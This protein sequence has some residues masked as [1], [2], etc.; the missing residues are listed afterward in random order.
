MDIIDSKVAE[1]WKRV[2]DKSP[3]LMKDWIQCFSSSSD[4]GKQ[5]SKEEIKMTLTRR[6]YQ[7]DPRKN[8]LWRLMSREPQKYGYVD[9]NGEC[10]RRADLA[11]LFIQVMMENSDWEDFTVTTLDARHSEINLTINLTNLNLTLCAQV[12]ENN[13]DETAVNLT[14]DSCPHVTGNNFDETMNLSVD[15]RPQTTENNLGET[16]TNFTLASRAQV[17]ENSLKDETTMNLTLASCPPVTE[18]NADKPITETITPLHKAARYENLKEVRK[19]IKDRENLKSNP[20]GYTPLHF[21]AMAI[22]PKHE[23]AKV[24]IGANKKMLNQQTA[25]EWG[26]NTALHIAAANTNVTE[27]FIQQFKD[28]KLQLPDSNN[29]TPFHV[30]AKS[31]NPQAII[32]MLN[33]FAPTNNCWDV[34]EVD[35]GQKHQNTLIKMCARRGNAK[36]VALLIKHGADISEGVLHEIVLQSVKTPK[37]I[38]KLVQ[39]YNSIVENVVTWRCL[40][41]QPEFLQT[42]ASDDYSKLFRETMIW[43]LTRPVK[44]YGGD[45]LQCALAHG[46][47]AMFWN[48]IN[49]KSVFRIQGD[50]IWKY[51]EEKCEH[52][53]SGCH[54]VISR[55]GGDET[56]RFVDREH[57]DGVDNNA[58]EDTRSSRKNWTVFDVTN[59]T[60]ETMLKRNPPDSAVES[61]DVT[62]TSERTALCSSRQQDE[63][64]QHA[65]ERS[66]EANNGQ[67]KPRQFGKPSVPDKPYLTCLLT[68]FDQWKCSNILSTQPFKELTESYI[69]FVQRFYFI[70]GLLQLIFMTSFTVFCMPTTCSLALMFSVSIKPAGCSNNTSNSSDNAM[71]PSFGQQRSWIALLWLIWPTIL[72]V[73]NAFMTFYCGRQLFAAKRGTSNKMVVKS[74]DV[75]DLSFLGKLKIALLRSVPLRIF[76]LTVFVWLYEYY[77]CGSSELYAKVTAMVLLFGWITNLSFFGDVSKNVSISVL[78]VEKIVVKDISSFMLF[79]GF[80]VVGFSFAMH[81]IRMSA[82]MPTQIIYLHETFF[83]VL[84]SA[85]GI[86]DFFETTITDPA[87]S[88]EG[89]QYLFEFVYLGYVCATM[90]ILLNILIAMIN[91]RYEKA[92]RKA[93]NVWRFRT[94]STMRA[95]ETMRANIL[96]LWN[97]P[98]CFGSSSGCCNGDKDQQSLSDKSITFN[99]HFKRYYL[100][101]ILPVDEKIQQL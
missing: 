48:I 68:V 41:E 80:S 26:Q 98:K 7:T 87:C 35:G 22:N 28:A 81:T 20:H 49:T 19:L 39:V 65:P 44:Q 8:F 90:I 97:Q 85:F 55:S 70:L 72:I 64:D 45:V 25:S 27:M 63:D 62:N 53:V 79:F 52:E 54:G 24:L 40:E 32:Y 83:A 59:F 43:L 30:A 38:S 47:S 12:A 14:S 2:Y 13:L 82:C 16:S 51:V 34:D 84:S 42:K 31:R 76:C 92:K 29:D 101:L 96:D 5:K 9:R 66:A 15:S 11:M 3:H 88:G 21:A 73:G 6:E 77:W 60:K 36:A 50:E 71:L 99:K 74:K 58:D 94:L 69:T 91:N 37:R 61:T 46:A 57:G 18:N 78:V 89:S 10:K 95:L 100:R 23:I 17:R 56:E 4:E 93:E 86:G 33:T 1:I 75:G 67:R